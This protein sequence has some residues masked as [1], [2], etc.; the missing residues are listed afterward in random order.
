MRRERPLEIAVLA[1][2]GDRLDQLV[3]AHAKPGRDAGEGPRRQGKAALQC[4]DDPAIGLAQHG[5]RGEP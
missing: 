2:A 4:V 3:L 5:S 1:Q